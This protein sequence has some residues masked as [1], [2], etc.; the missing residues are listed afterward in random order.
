MA[1]V[2]TIGA[3]GWSESG[4]F[5]ALVAA[6]VGLFCDIRRRRGVRGAEYAFVNSAR[7]QRRLHELGI[8]YTHRL[9]LAPSAE[10]RRVQAE[11]DDREGIARRSRSRLGDAFVA[12]YTAEHLSR[13]DP[14][15]FLAETASSGPVCLFCVEREPAACHRSLVANRLAEAGAR[16]T[17]LMP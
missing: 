12:A 13:F 10:V 17:H 1:E 16:V 6:R 14:T 3:F 5:D 15:A 4:F 8:P 11:I 7:L 9:D 2:V